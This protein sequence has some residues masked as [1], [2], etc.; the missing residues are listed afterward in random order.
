MTRLFALSAAAALLAACAS[1]QGRIES[2]LVEA[3]VPPPAARCMAPDLDHDLSNAQ[4]KE[5]GAVAAQFRRYPSAADRAAI[6]IGSRLDAG[7]VRAV[8]RTTAR[9]APDLGRRMISPAP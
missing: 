3:G 5:V 8:A 1:R 4:L 6:L 9:C 7:T 2:A